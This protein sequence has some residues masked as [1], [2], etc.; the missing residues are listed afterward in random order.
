MI[1][2][3]TALGGAKVGEIVPNSIAAI[4]LTILKPNSFSQRSRSGAPWSPLSN[5][6]FIS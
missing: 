1:F 5:A 6:P 2:V 4:H 3:I